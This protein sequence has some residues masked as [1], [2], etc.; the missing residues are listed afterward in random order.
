MTS[1]EGQGLFGRLLAALGRA[2]ERGILGRSGHDYMKQFGGSDEYWDRA[3]AAQLGWPQGPPPP[4]PG[5]SPPPGDAVA[6]AGPG[7]RDAGRRPP[8][9]ERGPVHGLAGRS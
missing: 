5:R 9:P 6:H 3:L 7:V 1:P 4:D 8:A 2:L